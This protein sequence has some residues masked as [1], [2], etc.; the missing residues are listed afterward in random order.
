MVL[1]HGLFAT[2]IV[3]PSTPFLYY[4]LQCVSS[5]F[6]VNVEALKQAEIASIMSMLLSQLNWSGHIFPIVGLQLLNIGNRPL[7]QRGIKEDETP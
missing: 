7:K 4:P 1:S 2:F 3:F 6:V 5:D